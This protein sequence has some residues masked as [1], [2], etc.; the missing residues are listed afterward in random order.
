MELLDNLKRTRKQSPEKKIQHQKLS[1]QEDTQ[2]Q[3]SQDNINF[4]T[5]SKSSYIPSE[6]V[7]AGN[8]LLPLPKQ[9]IIG[10][11]TRIVTQALIHKLAYVLLQEPT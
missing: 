4:P 9:Q 1:R 10:M 11:P 3:G 5:S 2:R 6:E 8:N 7:T